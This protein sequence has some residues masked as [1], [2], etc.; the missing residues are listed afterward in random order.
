M[1]NQPD[2]TTHTHTPVRTRV[3]PVLGM[4]IGNV[5]PMKKLPEN[6]LVKSSEGMICLMGVRHI[7]MLK[8]TSTHGVPHGQRQQRS[9]PCNLTRNSPKAHSNA[10]QLP[11]PPCGGRGPL[12]CGANQDTMTPTLTEIQERKRPKK[13]KKTKKNTKKNEFKKSIK[14]K[15]MIRRFLSL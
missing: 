11:G 13:T 1:G 12:C 7:D 5:G 9:R 6:A 10:P 15:K 14:K 3:R 8:A 4:G 2:R